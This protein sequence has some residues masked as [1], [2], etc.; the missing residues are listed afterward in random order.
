MFSILYWSL[1]TR[2]VLAKVLLYSFK[3]DEVA[4]LPETLSAVVKQFLEGESAC[5]TSSS[6]GAGTDMTLSNKVFG[7]VKTIVYYQPLFI[8]GRLSVRAAKFTA[9]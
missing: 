5:S 3:Q 6:P 8:F 9:W 1:K 7:L 4:S 2:N